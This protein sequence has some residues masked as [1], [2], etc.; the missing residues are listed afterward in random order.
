MM[1][2][3]DTDPD[4][5]MNSVAAGGSST[6]QK[7][8]QVPCFEISSWSPRGTAG[9]QFVSLVPFMQTHLVG[10]KESRAGKIKV[11]TTHRKQRLKEFQ[12]GRTT[13][14]NI[15]DER[16]LRAACND[17]DY[18][19]VVELLEGGADPSCEDEKKRTP[20]HIAASQGYQ[21][22]VRVLLDKGADPNKKDFIG[23][24]PLHLSACTCQ[25]PVVTLLLKAGTDIKSVDDYGRTPLKLARSRLQKL[26]GENK[27]CDSLRAE[28]KQ[29]SDMM[30][31]YL[32]ISGQ[33]ED[34]DQLES[35]CRQLEKTT[36]RE[37]VDHVNSLM[38]EFASLN[39]QKTDS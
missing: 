21:E 29:V 22:I 3:D 7:P 39:I 14:R 12:T 35:L 31:T 20:L 13:C 33:N 23:N 4:S 27:A 1:D 18:I 24:T 16:R 8:Y 5:D 15:V 11:S 28:I 19:T 17:N 38:A 34:A 25:I 32:R 10:D 9:L 6:E 26:V 36:T 37:E 30:T 2:K